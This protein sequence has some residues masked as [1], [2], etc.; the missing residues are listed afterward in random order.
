MNK[1]SSDSLMGKTVGMCEADPSKC[2]MMM[3][4]MQTHLNLMKSMKDMCDMPR[5]KMGQDKQVQHNH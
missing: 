5:I 2:S 4:A 3:L 1:C